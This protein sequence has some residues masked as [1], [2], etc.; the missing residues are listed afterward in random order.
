MPEGP[1]II[2]LKEEVQPFIGKKII[3]VEGNS[4]LDIQRLCGQ[5]IIDFK[6]WGKHFLICCEDF[7]VRIHFMLFGSYRINER[8]ENAPRLRLIFKKGEI[9]FYA[10]SVKFI[11]EDLDEV[12]DWTSDVM[13]DQW[14][15]KAA[16]RKLK[17]IPDTLVCD[18]LLDQQIFAGVGNIIKNEVLFRTYIHPESRVGSIPLKKIKELIK[19]A[20]NYSF[21]FLKWKKEY[22]LKKHWLAHTKIICPR[23]NI[24]FIKKYC[25][26]TNRRS[27]FC[28][29][30]QVNYSEEEPGW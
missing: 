14:D 26:K 3:K 19:E 24:R 20:R 17:K 8:K 23:C 9:N 22:V 15:A 2:I 21:D 7:T 4:Q 10:C 27:F 25:G 6:S 29:N 1:S 5:T 30:C 18:A 11:E 16:E 12:Y 13:S 28:N